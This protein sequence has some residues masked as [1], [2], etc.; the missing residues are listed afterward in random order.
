MSFAAVPSINTSRLDEQLDERFDYSNGDAISDTLVTIITCPIQQETSNMMVLFN[1][2]CYN[3]IDFDRYKEEE[4]RKSRGH[5]E[6]GIPT[7]LL[8]P[9]TG[10]EHPFQ[11]AVS[12]LYCRTLS[13]S[14]LQKMLVCQISGL[15]FAESSLYVLDGNGDQVITV[16]KFVTH[17]KDKRDEQV[18]QRN[19]YHEFIQE[20]QIDVNNNQPAHN[21]IPTQNISLLL[22]PTMNSD[23]T[24]IYSSSESDLSMGIKRQLF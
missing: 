19:S 8:D 2:Q 5:E 10:E 23:N 15:M 21:N 17:A 20:R 18:E 7:R 1:D 16:D 14:N 13:I 22:A 6:S 4:Y 24:S 11:N 12:N 3:L 9:R